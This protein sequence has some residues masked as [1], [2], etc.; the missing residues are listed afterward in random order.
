[1]RIYNLLFKMAKKISNFKTG[2]EPHKDISDRLRYV[3]NYWYAE[4]DHL[5]YLYVSNKGA[6]GIKRNGE[7]WIRVESWGEAQTGCLPVCKGDKLEVS[8]K[9]DGTV[10]YAYEF[11]IK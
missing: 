9:T 4:Y 7:L 10:M 1:M 5:L 2:I 6:L 8:I 11:K 3:G